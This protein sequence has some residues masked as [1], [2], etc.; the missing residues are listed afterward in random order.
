[1]NNELEQMRVQMQTL[2]EKLDKQE[3]INDKMIRN[4]INSK[5]SWI[6]KFVNIEFYLIPVVALMWLGVKYFIGMSW[7]SYAFMVIAVI[8][9]TIWDYRINDISLKSEEVETNSMTLTI[10]K[11]AEM[12]QMR[13]K[14]LRVMLPLLIAWLLWLCFE[15]W[16]HIGQ[17]SDS[18]NIIKVVTYGGGIGLLIGIPIG[19]FVAL[20]IYRK[21]QRTNDE[22]IAQI[23]DYINND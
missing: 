9:D 12:K 3:I 16:Q 2:S 19:I 7:F 21:M 22:L 15:T 14:Q 8:I 4:S 23:K 13:A 1:M 18:D 5:I 17:F 10:Q 6:R 11:L 20:Y